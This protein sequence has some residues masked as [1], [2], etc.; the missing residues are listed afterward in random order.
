MVSALI[1]RTSLCSAASAVRLRLSMH[2]RNAHIENTVGNN[3]PF[4]YDKK[5]PFAAKVAIFMVTGFS[6]PFIVAAWQM[7]KATA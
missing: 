1:A 3:M 2:V 4:K 5:G 7:H 6:L